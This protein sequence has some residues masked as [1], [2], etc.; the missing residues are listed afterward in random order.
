[1]L[2][3]KSAFIM[4]FSLPHLGLTPTE[5]LEFAQSR[6]FFCGPAARNILPQRRKLGNYRSHIQRGR[7]MQGT[8]K[9]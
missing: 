9:K 4:Y 1:M 6:F 8:N 5:V 7:E 2:G 3:G